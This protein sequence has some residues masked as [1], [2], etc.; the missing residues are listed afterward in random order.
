[1]EHVGLHIIGTYHKKFGREKKKIKIY[2][3]ECPIMALGKA[4]FA[5]CQARD[6]Q[7]SND[8]QL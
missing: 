8:R 6:T 4:F 1:M 2:F 5:E 3:A 7:Q